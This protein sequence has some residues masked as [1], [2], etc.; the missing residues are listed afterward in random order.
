MAATRFGSEPAPTARATLAALAGFFSVVPITAS[1][2]DAP[3]FFRKALFA[4]LIFLASMGRKNSTRR[5]GFSAPGSLTSPRENEGACEKR[6]LDG[7][8]DSFP[9]ERVPRR[10]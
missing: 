5:K 6:F 10:I 1:L 7:C 8:T 9:H 3:P 2:P 4:F